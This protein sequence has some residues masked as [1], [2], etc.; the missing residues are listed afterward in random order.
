MTETIEKFNLNHISKDK[1]YTKPQF[2]E[3]SNTEIN[4]KHDSIQK[5]LGVQTQKERNIKDQQVLK[6]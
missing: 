5:L 1:S 3:A 2:L 4:V 6:P